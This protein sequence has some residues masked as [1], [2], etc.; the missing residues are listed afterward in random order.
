MQ[1][2]TEE[3]IRDYQVAA[4]R[5]A[6]AVLDE[7]ELLDQAGPEKDR[8]IQRLMGTPN[9]LTEKPH[10]ASSAEKVV[11]L[12]PGYRAF[13]QEK[14]GAVAKRLGAEADMKASYLRALNA[15]LTGTRMEVVT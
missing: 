15:V 11:E 7:M 8:A 10:S 9:P 3:A 14:G 6:K 12:D 1:D 13:L 4:G 5:H 2:V